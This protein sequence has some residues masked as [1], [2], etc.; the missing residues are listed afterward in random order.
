MDRW[1][2]K[3]IMKVSNMIWTS[4]LPSFRG[5]S[6]S[7]NGVPIFHCF[8]LQ[9][10][11]YHCH[12]KKCRTTR[13]SWV[14]MW[15]LEPWSRCDILRTNM[16]KISG[17]IADVLG[18]VSQEYH[19]M[20]SLKKWKLNRQQT[21]SDMFPWQKFCANPIIEMKHVVTSFFNGMHV[22]T[23]R[24]LHFQQ[25]SL[26]SNQLSLIFNLRYWTCFWYIKAFTKQKK[27]SK[28]NGEWD[29]RQ[30]MC[31]RWHKWITAV[32]VLRGTVCPKVRINSVRIFW[33]TS[34][35]C[36]TR[37]P[38]GHGITKIGNLPKSYWRSLGGK[39]E[40]LKT[41][42]QNSVDTID[43]NR[44]LR[45]FF[46][47][48]MRCMTRFPKGSFTRWQQGRFMSGSRDVYLFI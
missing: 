27:N 42:A 28:S 26:L 43:G 18:G 14:S 17:M 40:R 1:K 19:P 33:A 2:S 47:V 45:G 37:K 23:V 16:A 35:P 4:G 32:I 10:S 36:F 34:P 30:N 38:S 44:D 48:A 12:E 29:E 39:M 31:I 20:V 13:E 21:A 7:E 25:I 6:P 15:A 5:L 8:T 11:P 41:W 22:F 3:G 24:P 46:F 9:E